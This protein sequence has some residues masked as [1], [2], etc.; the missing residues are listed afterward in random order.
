MPRRKI[1]STTLGE[2]PS[3]PRLSQKKLKKNP[4]GEID[5]QKLAQEIL[6]QQQISDQSASLSL[7]PVPNHIDATQ[8][9]PTDG[10]KPTTEH[11][12]TSSDT[13]LRSQNVTSLVSQIFELHE[14]SRHSRYNI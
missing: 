11:P 13:G 8:Q 2:A 4:S 6:K 14:A 12:S 9:N 5:Y 7:I 1:I 3:S 10:S